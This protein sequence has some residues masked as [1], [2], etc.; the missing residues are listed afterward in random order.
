MWSKLKSTLE[1]R[2]MH[3]TPILRP[4][5]EAEE[6]EA[7]LQHLTE[8]TVTVWIGPP[9]A[10]TGEGSC[11]RPTD[12]TNP[13]RGP[14]HAGS[15][16]VTQFNDRVRQGPDSEAGNRE[17]RRDPRSGASSRGQAGRAATQ[18]WSGRASAQYNSTRGLTAPPAGNIVGEF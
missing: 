13:D 17:S 6:T 7:T 1:R 12:S 16:A 18:H 4:Q 5:P 3:K 2:L 11:M 15:R 9:G 10:R 14:E 8:S